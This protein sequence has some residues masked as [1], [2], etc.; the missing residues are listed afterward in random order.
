M[1]AKARLIMRFAQING[2]GTAPNH[3]H[4][5]G[6]LVETTAAKRRRRN[7]GGGQDYALSEKGVKLVS[8]S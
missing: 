8:V 7:D 2:V 5:R 4:G 3:K 1:M 6:R